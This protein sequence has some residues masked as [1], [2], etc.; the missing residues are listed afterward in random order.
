MIVFLD[1]DILIDVATDRKPFSEDS[2]RVLDM[3]ER[4]LFSTFVA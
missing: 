3:A 4:H 1:T 2:S